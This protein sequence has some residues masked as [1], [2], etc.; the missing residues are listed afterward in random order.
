MTA[1]RT[2]EMEQPMTGTRPR[3]RVIWNA[4]AGGKAA[5][6]GGRPDEKALRDL[7]ARHGLGEDLVATQSE[8]H[9]VQAVREARDTGYDTVVAAGGDG[10][11]AMAATELLGSSTALGILP[12]GTVM[13]I[14]RMLEIPRELEE[15]AAIL[16]AGHRRPIDVGF[17]GDKPF[18]EAALVGI[19]AAVFRHVTRVEEG[20]RRALAR[21][22]WVA[23]RY[24]PRRMSVHLD[25]GVAHTRALLVTVALGPYSGLAFTVAPDAQLDDGLFEV[26]L[27]RHYSKFELFR[28]LVSIA[29]GRRSWS[30]HTV[31][32]RSAKVRIESARPLPARADSR[33]LGSTPVEFTIRPRVLNVI[34]PPT[35]A[36]A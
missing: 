2:A 7:M 11:V 24:R 3:I 9:A 23:F 22:I 21:A 25:D 33:D 14:C 29:F 6:P 17:V 36:S 20:D 27:F 34:V 5:V 1:T 30:P 18:Y 13:N 32:Y 4:E 19:N 10:T 12:L 31:T 8:E 26:T 35:D 16:A 15:A 28:Y